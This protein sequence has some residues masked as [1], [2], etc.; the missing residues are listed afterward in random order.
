[1]GV[2]LFLRGQLAMSETV[3]VVKLG[4]ERYWQLVSRDQ[5]CA[6]ILQCTGH[7]SPPQQRIIWPKMSIVPGVGTES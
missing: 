2:I 7:P 5:D 4:E 3:L 1:M 6:N